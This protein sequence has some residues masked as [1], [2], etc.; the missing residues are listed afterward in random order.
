VV[1]V[2]ENFARQ[3]WKTPAEALGKR[4]RNSPQSLWREIVGVVGNER[5]D[6]VDQK[7]PQIVYW[8]L[9]VDRMWDSGPGVWRRQTYAVRSART[10]TDALLKEIREVVR[11]VD[12]SLPVT[13]VRT[14]QRIYER[15]MARTSFTLALLGI[16]SAMALLLGLVGIYGV[17][18]YSVSQRTREIGIRMALG[19]EDREVRGMFVRHAFL[20]TAVG[21]AIGVGAA[22][23]LTR[24]MSSLLFEVNPVD[25]ITYAAVAA[26]LV[27]AALL[28]SYLPAR[29]ATAVDPARA[30]RAE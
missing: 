7:A 25:P 11:S 4:I 27:A 6:G 2:S 13:N 17:I 5:D 3:Y 21:V 15:S 22:V 30:L 19:A 29:R 10:G 12:A 23:A 24:A 18:S 16:A 1:Q 8:P 9:V 28:A 26:I 14:L 20:L